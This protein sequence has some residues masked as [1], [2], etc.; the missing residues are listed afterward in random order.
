MMEGLFESLELIQKTALAAGEA[1]GKLALVSPPAEPK[2]VYL[3]IKPD[4][5]Y[6]KLEAEPAPRAHTLASLDQVAPYAEEKGG[7]S[8]VVWYDE[9]GVTVILDDRTRRDVARLKFETTPQF[10][11]VV[12]LDV[13]RPAFSQRDFRKLIR[14]DLAGC[15]ESPRLLT[16]VSDVRFGTATNAAGNLR[17][18]RESL[19]RDIDAQAVSSAGEIP[20]EVP[21]SVRIFADP[22]LAGRQ[23]IRC[24]FDLDV[25][26]QEFRLIPL[27]L[28][29][30]SAI[31]CE[32]AYIGEKLTGELDGLDV[33]LFRGRP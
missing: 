5:S 11:R 25:Q 20:D 8:T 32:L 22:A 10:Q 30:R 14:I 1:D 31:D 26:S 27:P 17:N 7:E 6:E 19:G 18:E 9:S 2:H 28:Q 3:A 16:W 21:L 23:G 13:E 4:G 24:V 12:R 33:P 29:V 15:F